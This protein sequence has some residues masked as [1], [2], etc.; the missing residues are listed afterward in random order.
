MNHRSAAALFHVRMTELGERERTLDVHAHPAVPLLATGLH[1]RAV[2]PGDSGVVDQDIHGAKRAN[3][4]IDDSRPLFLVRH[5]RGNR[6]ASLSGRLDFRAHSIQRFEPARNERHMRAVLSERERDRSANSLRAAGNHPDFAFKRM[7]HDW[8]WTIPP[9][10]GPN[11][12]VRPVPCGS[13][14]SRNRSSVRSEKTKAD[15]SRTTA[16]GD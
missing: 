6:E 8:H 15:R 11:G 7:V 13:G 5:I 12:P 9:A 10:I 3:G 1:D 16:D 14:I 4:L 2:P